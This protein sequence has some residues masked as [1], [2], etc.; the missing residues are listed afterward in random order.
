MEFI[1]GVIGSCCAVGMLVY[2]VASRRG[3]GKE[4]YLCKEVARLNSWAGD[5]E[6][7]LRGVE[8]EQSGVRVDLVALKNE[9]ARLATLIEKRL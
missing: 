3:N 9:V 1:F 6:K 8:I 5:Q 2:H 4:K 7:R